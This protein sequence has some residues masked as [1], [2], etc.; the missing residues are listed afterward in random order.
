MLIW[1][2]PASSSIICAGREGLVAVVDRAISLT[3][4]CRLA[5]WI[6]TVL[7]LSSSRVAGSTVAIVRV[8]SLN[9]RIRVAVTVV[10][11]GVAISATVSIDSLLAIVVS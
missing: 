7:G 5:I 3:N 6:G 9:L 4:V 2:P 11:A 8:I 10:L 1:A